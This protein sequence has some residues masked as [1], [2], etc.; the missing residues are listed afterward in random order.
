MGDKTVQLEDFIKYLQ[1]IR[2][3][4]GNLK[5]SINGRTIHDL[6]DNIEIEP[7][8]DTLDIIS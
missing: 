7:F 2:E 4:E 6:E 8:G 3:T 5:M 1:G